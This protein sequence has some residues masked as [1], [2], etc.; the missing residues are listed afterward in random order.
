[1]EVI[2]LFSGG[3]LVL[4]GWLIGYY[5][6]LQRDRRCD[7][8]RIWESS[9]RFPDDIAVGAVRVRCMRR[10]GHRDEHHYGPLEEYEY[11]SA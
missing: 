3:I 7:S 11:V 8:F 4:V 2:L 5:T 10:E 6:C 9:G 1:M